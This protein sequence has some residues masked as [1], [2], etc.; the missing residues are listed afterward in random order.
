MSVSCSSHVQ[1]V[2]QK[3]S[4]EYKI[5][6]KGRQM[7]IAWKKYFTFIFLISKRFKNLPLFHCFK[8]VYLSSKKKQMWQNFYFDYCSD[9]NK[10][11]TVQT[12]IHIFKFSKAILTN[13]LRC[14]FSIA[15]YQKRHQAH[16]IQDVPEI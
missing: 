8:T 13:E 4:E 10:T 7:A 6:L 9:Y 3:S 5:I 11:K 14:Q 1:L 15:S 12:L 2:K 16:I